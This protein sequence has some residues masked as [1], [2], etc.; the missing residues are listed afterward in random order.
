MASVN[1]MGLIGIIVIV[2]SLLGKLLI[3][4]ILVVG[5]LV[6][7]LNQ[8]GVT[9]MTAS[10]AIPDSHWKPDLSPPGTQMNSM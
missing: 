7:L 4:D 9:S 2:K 5:Y 8:I 3:L 1:Q 10:Q 6:T